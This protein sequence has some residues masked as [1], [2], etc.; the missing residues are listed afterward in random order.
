MP[1]TFAKLEPRNLN[2]RRLPITINKSLVRDEEM[3]GEEYLVAPV[4]LI[5]QGVHNGILYLNED[6]KK[7]PAAWNGAPLVVNHPQDPEGNYISAN[8]PNMAINHVGRV[9]EVL[10]SED[11]NGEGRLKGELWVNK[12]RCADISPECLERLENE[13]PLEVSTGLWTEDEIVEGKWNT[14]SYAAIAHNHRPDHLA[15]LPQDVGACSWEDGAGAPRVNSLHALRK[16]ILHDVNRKIRRKAMKRN[17]L[18]YRETMDAV[19]DA[20]KEYHGD[21]DEMNVQYVW[22]RDI[23]GGQVIYEVE[24]REPKETEL[25]QNDPSYEWKQAYVLRAFEV[26]LDDSITIDTEF[27]QVKLKQTYVPVPEAERELAVNSKTANAKEPSHMKKNKKTREQEIAAL[28]GNES[29]PYTEDDREALAAMSDATFSALVEANTEDPANAGDD[30]A[31]GDEPGAKQ[32]AAASDPEPTPNTS[33]NGK[34]PTFNELLESADPETRDAIQQGIATNKAQKSALVETLSANERCPYSKDELQGKDLSELQ[35][36]NR[37]AGGNSAEEDPEV[38][39][40][41]FRGLVG[42]IQGNASKGG[43]EPF[44]PATHKPVENK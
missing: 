6:L 18:S 16:N 27:T 1:I 23:K 14:E 15:L 34:K 11:E 3:D 28:I 44:I 31:S 26:G 24:W 38:D 35:K 36:L 7:F 22:V 33:G 9:F 41:D 40:S 42:N 13:E 32:A 4:V 20:L 2:R 29:T 8:S 30:G 10:Y 12:A 21:N 39:L 25:G 5:T 19:Q 17:S 43:A 37:L